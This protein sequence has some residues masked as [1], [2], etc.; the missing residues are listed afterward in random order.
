[1]QIKLAEL[2]TWTILKPLSKKEADQD[3]IQDLQTQVQGFKDR[4]SAVTERLANPPAKTA[5]LESTEDLSKV[6]VKDLVEG[7]LH[8]IDMLETKTHETESAEVHPMLEELENK[9]WEV[10]QKLGIKPEIPEHEKEEP[11]HKEIVEEVEKEAAMPPLPA[12][13]SSLPADM[14]YVL[15][16]DGKNWI[17]KVKGTGETAGTTGTPGNLSGISG[18]GIL[19]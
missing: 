16:P 12:D 18:G 10:E 5:D 17:K 1:M 19:S 14:E 2:Q 13:A 8:M 3:P 6:D 7:I 11:E 15:S 9:V 4:M